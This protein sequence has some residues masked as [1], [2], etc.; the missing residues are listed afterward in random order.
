MG[1]LKCVFLAGIIVTVLAGCQQAYLTETNNTQRSQIEDCMYYN[2]AINHA[3]TGDYDR[4]VVYLSYAMKINPNNSEL[5]WYRGMYYFY[6]G[7]HTLAITDLNRF[8]GFNSPFKEGYFYR[9]LVYYDMGDLVR[10]YADFK[11]SGWFNPNYEE[12]KSL[13][14]YIRQ[15]RNSID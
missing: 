9:G 5:Y 12:I 8:I 7:D 13:L 4:A 3:L 6:I 14:E 1:R 2:N 10:A 15:F 11:E